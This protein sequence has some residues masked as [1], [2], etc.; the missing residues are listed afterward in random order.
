MEAVGIWLMLR[1]IYSA[2]LARQ[3]NRNMVGWFLAGLISG[4]FALLL[5]I[6]FPKIEYV[7]VSR[8]DTKALSK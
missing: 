7:F 6:F 2:F 4:P 5:L 8:Y 1:A 3:K